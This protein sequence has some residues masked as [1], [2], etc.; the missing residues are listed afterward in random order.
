MNE[1]LNSWG[2]DLNGL[3]YE[4]INYVFN[5][6]IANQIKRDGFY[7]ADVIENSIDGYRRLLVSV[8]G[9]GRRM[10]ALWPKKRL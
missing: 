7:R 10:T 3:N 5:R 8:G 2:I 1:I 4:E 6:I 9:Q